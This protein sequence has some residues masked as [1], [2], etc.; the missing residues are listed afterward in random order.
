M[1]CP[2]CNST[3]K[4]DYRGACP[5]CLRREANL[6]REEIERLRDAIEKHRRDVW[7]DREVEHDSDIA[8]YAVLDDKGK[9]GD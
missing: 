7:G 4:P 9:D 1:I 3:Q 8:L 6:L 5:T 2:E